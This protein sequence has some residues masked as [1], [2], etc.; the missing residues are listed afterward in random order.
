MM[1]AFAMRSLAA[2][3]S[4][5]TVISAFPR[6]SISSSIQCAK[7]PPTGSALSCLPDGACRELEGQEDLFQREGEYAVRIND[8]FTIDVMPAAC[9]HRFRELARYIEL[10][11]LDGVQL[12]LMGLA[13]SC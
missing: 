11:D 2:T 9:G 3:P 7:T 1:P 8:E 12:P 13:G 6:T 4:P 5:L 10:R